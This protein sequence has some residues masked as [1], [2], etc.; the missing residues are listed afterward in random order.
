[1]LP[2]SSPPTGALSPFAQADRDR[3]GGPGQRGDV[4]AQRDRRVEDPRPIDVQ[5]QAALITE[6][7]QPSHRGDVGHRAAS[8]VVRV[9]HAQHGSWRVVLVGLTQV[10]AD[11]LGG[12][13]A[14]V[15]RDG[16]GHH[17]AEHRHAARLV[18]HDVGVRL[19][20]GLGTPFRGR[21]HGAQV[22]H[23]AGRHEDRVLVA[24]DGR[25]KPL[26]LV[27]G[28]VSVV[29]VVAEFGVRH[30]LDHRRCRLG[31]RV[32]E[33]QHPFTARRR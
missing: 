7:P 6:C 3:V 4:D 15:S 28:R 10:P 31:R 33:A 25:A 8:P 9:L 21:K 18:V 30:R 2:A 17:P 16:A 27:H 22:G 24:E 13:H 19:G 14:V 23:G 32:V 1:L 5:V 12:Q 11:Q 26:E 20:D 29:N